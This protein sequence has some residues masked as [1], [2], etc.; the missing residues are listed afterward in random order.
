MKKS[1]LLSLMVVLG[2]VA[3]AHPPKKVNITY[4]KETG[5]ITVTAEHKVKDAK[6]HYIVKAYVM[7]NDEEIKVEDFTEQTNLT[8]AELVIDM[9]E[10]K[11]GDVVKVKAKCNKSGARAAEIVI[12]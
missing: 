2:L 7:V 8:T 12:E 10:L 6:K 5:K 9:P 4:D 3:L 1:L 11:A